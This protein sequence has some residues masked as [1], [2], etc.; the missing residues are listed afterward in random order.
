[1]KSFS[2]SHFFL[3]LRRARGEPIFSSNLAARN[4]CVYEYISINIRYTID[5]AIS[6][7][8]ERPALN[9]RVSTFN[10]FRI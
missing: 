9:M 8:F 3:Y 1:M 2:Q 7:K 10:L 5:R 4:S 6:F